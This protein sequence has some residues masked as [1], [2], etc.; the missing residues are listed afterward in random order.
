MFL[1][2]HLSHFSPH[3]Q[4]EGLHICNPRLSSLP[5]YAPTSPLCIRGIH[6]CWD[7]PSQKHTKETPLW[8]PLWILLWQQS[9]GTIQEWGEPCASQLLQQEGGCTSS[10]AEPQGL[11]LWHQPHGCKVGLKSAVRGNIRG[12]SACFWLPPCSINCCI[13]MQLPGHEQTAKPC[14]HSRHSAG[15]C[16]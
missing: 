9:L 15:T 3:Y 12:P 7:L 1:K 6:I 10:F 13:L 4:I 14:K 2:A 5:F 11:L 16:P 8:I